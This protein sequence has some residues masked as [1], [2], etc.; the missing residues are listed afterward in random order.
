[1]KRAFVI[2]NVD[3]GKYLSPDYMINRWVQISVAH[4]FDTRDL[5]EAELNCT[6]EKNQLSHIYKNYTIFKVEEIFVN[7]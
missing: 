7:D 1:M 3:L 4:K 6:D 2:L 5:A